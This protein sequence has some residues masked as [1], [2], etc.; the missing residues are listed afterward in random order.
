MSKQTIT[1]GCGPKASTGDAALDAMFEAGSS[2]LK[3]DNYNPETVPTELKQW[4]NGGCEDIREQTSARIVA[5]SLHLRNKIELTNDE[6]NLCLGTLWR[7][8]GGMEKQ[9]DFVKDVAEQMNSVTEQVADLDDVQVS[10][11]PVSFEGVKDP[12]EIAARM[13]GCPAV[14][15]KRQRVIG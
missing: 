1:I 14:E 5:V 15:A 8:A 10:G 3:A 12:L 9:L 6:L 13:V 11:H 4:L 7:R 2:M